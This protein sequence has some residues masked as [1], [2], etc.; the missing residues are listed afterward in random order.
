MG[1][2]VTHY[3]N[4][5]QGVVLVEL[6]KLILFFTCFI[7]MVNYEQ[8]SPVDVTLTGP[9]NSIDNNIIELV[10]NI[11]NYILT[12]H[13]TDEVIEML[14]EEHEG[15]L[16]NI[17]IEKLV[18]NIERLLNKKYSVNNVLDIFA[19]N[20][21]FEKFYIQKNLWAKIKNTYFVLK[22]TATL[23][24]IVVVFYLLYLLAQ[25]L[26]F[27]INWF[28]NEDQR[29]DNKIPEPV[30]ARLDYHGSNP[31]SPI[32]QVL[33]EQ[34][35][36]CHHLHAQQTHQ[37]NCNI[38]TPT[39]QGIPKSSQNEQGLDGSLYPNYEEEIDDLDK[40]DLE[41]SHSIMEQVKQARTIGLEIELDPTAIS[42]RAIENIP[43]GDVGERVLQ[44]VKYAKSIGLIP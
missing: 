38:P 21:E 44:Q 25:W 20:K 35:A 17:N 32:E 29:E 41:L 33:L 12:G 14:N 11:C 26:K 31:E 1:W 42:Q 13:S 10:D 34:V 28:E 3:T 19:I 27:K 15:H 22:S 39:T 4:A 5:V 16:Y 36:Q 43:L 24:I 40:L 7:V 18:T 30:N 9:V 37:V 6:N 2:P 23:V 8:L